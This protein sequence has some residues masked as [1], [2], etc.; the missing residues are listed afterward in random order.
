[1]LTAR[2]HL[3]ILFLADYVISPVVDA[4][5]KAFVLRL[6][7]L[8][9][10]AC[11]PLVPVSLV[12]P[13]VAGFVSLA[14]LFLLLLPVRLFGA[15]FGA[16]LL[17]ATSERFQ[18]LLQSMTVHWVGPLSEELVDRALLQ[19]VIFQRAI[20]NRFGRDDDK[21]RARLWALSRVACALHFGCGHAVAYTALVRNGV[22]RIPSPTNVL[23]QCGLTTLAAYFVYCPAY[24]HAGLAA[25]LAAHVLW[26][27]LA[28]LYAWSAFRMLT[29]LLSPLLLL[30]LLSSARSER[31]ELTSDASTIGR[32]AG[33]R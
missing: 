13:T 31:L 8:F 19:G 18:D 32:W 29:L 33:Q 27:A 4:L 22:P 30:V 10:V 21:L 15:R 3:P 17:D 5:P 2:Y 14:A 26:N 12:V 25:S 20:I 9:A 1:M 16:P 28:A 11:E 23:S 24:A 6:L 7:E